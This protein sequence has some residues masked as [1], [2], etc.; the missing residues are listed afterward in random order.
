MMRPFIERGDMF[1]YLPFA[2]KASTGLRRMAPHQRDLWWLEPFYSGCAN[3]MVDI[4]T[5]DTYTDNRYV[6]SRGIYR[7]ELL[8]TIKQKFAEL[9]VNPV[10]WVHTLRF[11]TPQATRDSREF[12]QPC[13]IVDAM[14]QGV[15]YIQRRL[16][17]EN[18]F[19]QMGLRREPMLTTPHLVPRFSHDEAETIWAAMHLVNQGVSEEDAPV[20]FH[21][22]IEKRDS[23]AYMF[24]QEGPLMTS[25]NWVAH[26]FTDLR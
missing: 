11:F 7:K 25:M 26:K 12:E 16:F 8:E 14:I 17:L 4:T 19:P 22:I 13:L 24:Q 21:G 3:V 1:A 2:G 6:M 18:M 20:P 23:S 9:S 15:T 5:G 10:K